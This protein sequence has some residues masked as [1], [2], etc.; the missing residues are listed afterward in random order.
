MIMKYSTK[1]FLQV[2]FLTLYPQGVDK[3]S[4]DLSTDF[5]KLSTKNLSY[6]QIICST[7]NRTNVRILFIVYIIL[8]T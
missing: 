4:T 8:Y 3:L 5:L 6:P 1:I 7:I 2:I